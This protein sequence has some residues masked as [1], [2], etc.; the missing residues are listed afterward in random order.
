MTN[1][2]SPNYQPQIKVDDILRDSKISA[3][4]TNQRQKQMKST[5]KA[6]RKQAIGDLGA[7]SKRKRKVSSL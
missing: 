3:T 4:R 6:V 2:F 1:A 5:D 7:M